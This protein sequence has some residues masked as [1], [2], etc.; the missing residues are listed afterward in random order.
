MPCHQIVFANLLVVTR[1]ERDRIHIR[2]R[3][4]R[5]VGQVQYTVPVDSHAY[6]RKKKPPIAP[7][8]VCHAP[9][10]FL[11]SSKVEAIRRQD[12]VEL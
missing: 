11:R 2:G 6:R 9:S 12:E 5:L 3:R 4:L 1:L 10:P 7:P 8:L